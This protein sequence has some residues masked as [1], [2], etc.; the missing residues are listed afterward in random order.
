MEPRLHST[1]SYMDASD[2]TLRAPRDFLLG[3][4]LL[5][6]MTTHLS[7]RRPRSARSR[8][9]K[10]NGDTKSV[11]GQGLPSP[12]KEVDTRR[13]T[14]GLYHYGARLGLARVDISAPTPTL[15]EER[16]QEG[17]DWLYNMQVGAARPHSSTQSLRGGETQPHSLTSDS[18]FAAGQDPQGQVRRTQAFL[19]ALHQDGASV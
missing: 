14:T 9:T 19:H 13:K 7:P 8:T 3:P 15:W 2:R 4:K 1:G 17:Q 16:I 5:A 6:F 18:L 11:K 12:S 10:V